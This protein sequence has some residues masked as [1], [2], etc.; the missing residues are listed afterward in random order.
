MT[1]P[2]GVVSASKSP[3]VNLNFS[4]LSQIG[5]ARTTEMVQI[6]RGL[7]KSRV[8]AF[9][10]KIGTTNTGKPAGDEGLITPTSLGSLGSNN[11]GGRLNRS[12]SR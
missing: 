7:T 3:P 11:G 12:H 9:E 8:D 1:M 6:Q 2:G 4:P 10:K 5:P